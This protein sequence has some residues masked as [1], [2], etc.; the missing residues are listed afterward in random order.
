MKTAIWRS[1]WYE[2]LYHG[3]RIF[4]L[5]FQPGTASSV[6]RLEERSR[7]DGECQSISVLALQQKF[8]SSDD[9][10][11]NHDNGDGK[12]YPVADAFS[13]LVGAIT[14]DSPRAY[15]RAGSRWIV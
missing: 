10:C 8:L 7:S 11:T 15:N 4:V 3:V 14:V 12:Q 5:V 13:R 9:G 2:G 1:H 6:L